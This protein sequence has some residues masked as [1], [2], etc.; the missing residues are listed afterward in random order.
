MK[1][2][3]RGGEGGL[4]EPIK[5]QM[6]TST[7]VHRL[8]F[9]AVLLHSIILAILCVLLQFYQP[10][11]IYQS[12]LLWFEPWRL[13]TAHWVHVGWAH[14]ALNLTALLLLPWIFPTYPTRRLWLLL[15]LGCP[16]LSLLFYLM[17]PNLYHYAGLSGILHGIYFSAAAHALLSRADRMVA[18]ILLFGLTIKLILENWIVGQSSAELI[19]APVLTQAHYFGV[20]VVLVLSGVFGH[21][22][23]NHPQQPVN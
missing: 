5:Q 11:L 20:A 14:V 12:N 8:T 13:W 18:L 3:R 10:H 21:F 22:V 7:D 19:G 9:R 23:E 16:L 15:L 1:Q 17:L 4:D 6:I 2:L